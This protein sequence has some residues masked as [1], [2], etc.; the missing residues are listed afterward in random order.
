MNLTNLTFRCTVV[1]FLVS[2]AM[3]AAQAPAAPGAPP[4]TSETAV[5]VKQA[6]QLNNEGKQDEAG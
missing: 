2:G 5:L 3:L 4:P 6:Q 1:W